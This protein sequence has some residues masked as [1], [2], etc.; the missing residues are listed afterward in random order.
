MRL[1]VEIKA[2]LSDMVDQHF[3]NMSAEIVDSDSE[4]A[5]L[6]REGYGSEAIIDFVYKALL[7]LHTKEEIANMLKVKKSG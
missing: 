5:F 4:L 2:C 3:S 7:G 1:R 6:Q